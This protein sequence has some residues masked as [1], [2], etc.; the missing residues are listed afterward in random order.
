MTILDW[1]P[2]NVPNVIEVDVLCSH[3][4]SK[5]KILIDRLSKLTM[6]TCS[7]C[8]NVELEMQYK[9]IPGSTIKLMNRLQ[10]HDFHHNGIPINEYIKQLSACKN[11]KETAVGI[12]RLR[13]FYFRFKYKHKIDEELFPDFEQFIRWSVKNGY[14]DWKTLEVDNDYLDANAKWVPG[15]Y[16][17]KLGIIEAEPIKTIY[18]CKKSLQSWFN[19]LAEQDKQSNIAPIIA[20]CINKLAEAQAQIELK[21]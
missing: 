11:T 19:K 7:N 6:C 1:R 18:D 10:G 2:A 13:S 17:N 21:M 5:M 15:G 16:I 9:S 20:S 8:N 4:G 12:Y 14:R 3:C